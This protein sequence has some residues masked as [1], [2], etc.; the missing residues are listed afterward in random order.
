M[1]LAHPPHAGLLAEPESRTNEVG[2]EVRRGGDVGD[3]WR[4]RVGGRGLEAEHLLLHP[5]PLFSSLP[6]LFT[7]TD[8]ID[9]RSV[10]RI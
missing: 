4:W 9:K 8:A 1:P 10:G 5:H 3:R 7:H 2:A 6:P